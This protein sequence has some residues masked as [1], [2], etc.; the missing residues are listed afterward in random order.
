MA[1]VYTTAPIP[2]WDH[3][4]EII[5]EEFDR[6]YKDKL[7]AELHEFNRERFVFEQVADLWDDM[8][9]VHRF[10]RFH[11]QHPDEDRWDRPHFILK[12]PL[13]LF[14]D[15]VDTY[16]FGILKTKVFQMEETSYRPTG[17][18][19][20]H[21]QEI[22]SLFCFAERYVSIKDMFPSEERK[23]KKF[24]VWIVSKMMEFIL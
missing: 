11:Y 4:L 10:S 22:R 18:L 1:I 6:E 13:G 20:L 7:T 19:T 16:T 8:S 23:T 21:I 14:A 2:E 17:R 15:K 5:E 12:D 24:T 3:G 9:A